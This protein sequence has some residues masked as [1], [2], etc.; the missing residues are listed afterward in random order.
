MVTSYEGPMYYKEQLAADHDTS[1]VLRLPDS[2][3]QLVDGK[4]IAD[5][6]RANIAGNPD[7]RGRHFPAAGRPEWR[8][9]VA[10]LANDPR[11]ARKYNS[12]LRYCKRQGGN[13]ALCA[14][15]P[16]RAILYATRELAEGEEIFYNYG[17]EK[18]FEHLRKEA[19]R[20]QT[21]Q[22]LRQ[23]RESLRMVWV[24][25]EEVPAAAV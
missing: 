9:G 25:Y 15:A 16:M 8:H 4:P 18:P 1:Y 6:I 3:G 24:P 13:K 21:E 14:L 20:K 17:S 7:A 2:G 10:S 23:K 12:A 5:A 22:Q 11:D 19:Q